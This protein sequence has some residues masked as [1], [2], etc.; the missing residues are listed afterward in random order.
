MI[1]YIGFFLLSSLFLYA[2]DIKSSSSNDYT[3]EKPKNKYGNVLAEDGKPEIEPMEVPLI[4]PMEVPVVYAIG[5][6]PKAQEPMK[7]TQKQKPIDKS[8]YFTDKEVL[9]AKEVKTE[10]IKT[11]SGTA[12]FES[13]NKADNTP[14]DIEK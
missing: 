13:L 9:N 1:K 4:E 14:V 10:Q 5:D 11:D 3:L 12:F 8:A 2:I 7:E 6:K